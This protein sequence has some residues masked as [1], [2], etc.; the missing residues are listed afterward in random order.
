M[1][2]CKDLTIFLINFY[3][4]NYRIFPGYQNSVLISHG[5]ILSNADGDFSISFP[6]DPST[7][8]YNESYI[9]EIN[10]KFSDVTGETNEHSTT[11]RISSQSI[12]LKTELKDTYIED[13]I[14]DHKVIIHNISEQP[15]TGD[16][17]LEVY[18]FA[19]DSK[20]KR[21]KYWQEIDQYTINE[22]S[23]ANLFPHYDRQE[24]VLKPE[25]GTLV[26]SDSFE[27]DTI[28]VNTLK[29][30]KTG[31]YLIRYI[32]AKDGG[33]AQ[34]FDKKLEVGSL[35]N[36]TV[37]TDY[38]WHNNL[39]NIYQPGDRFEFKVN[40]P[41]DKYNVYYILTQ[42]DKIIDQAWINQKSKGINLSI[43]ETWRG[44]CASNGCRDK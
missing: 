20:L 29:D 38:L 35:K 5:T 4:S 42:K 27:G 24:L 23:Y 9:Y 36:K 3:S 14:D 16:V 26:S 33:I 22:K 34:T 43:N 19:N 11:V 18:K 6:T 1:R 25:N 39:K 7:K 37:A 12:Y 21:K 8:S 32:V 28:N 31:L 17:K 44:R 10:I 13:N 15:L 30:L 2:F 41:S 40:T